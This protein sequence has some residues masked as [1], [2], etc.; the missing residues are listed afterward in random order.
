MEVRID[1]LRFQRDGRPVI[2]IPRLHFRGGRTTAILGPN[3]SGKTTLLRLIAALERPT[4]GAITVGDWHAS[5]SRATRQLIGFAFQEAVLLGGSVRENLALGLRLRGVPK[6]ERAMRIDVAAQEC[7]IHP[8]L[9]RR[10]LSLSGGEAQ[11][12]NLARALC[13][14]APLT[15]LDEPLSGLDAGTRARLLD[16]MPRLLQTFAST[17]IL[18]TH[19]RDEALRLADDLVVLIGGAVRAAGEKEC[20]LREPPDPEVASVLGYSVVPLTECVVAFPPGA[21]TVGRGRIPFE[22]VVEGL[23]DMGGHREAFGRIGGTRVHIRLPADAATPVPGERLRV[24]VD[25]AVTFPAGRWA[26]CP[27]P[28]AS[29]HPAG[30]C[31]TGNG[32]GATRPEG[33]RRAGGP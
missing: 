1:G 28:P 9:D 3:G 4:A 6:A 11:R 27:H 19:D 5:P 29:G 30:G 17:T 22:L 32:A 21:L 13:L 33:T 15:L 16:D 24:G 18:V 12:V 8:L 20:V 31:Q 2:A 14:R 23:V 7:G 26:G 25:S 10:A